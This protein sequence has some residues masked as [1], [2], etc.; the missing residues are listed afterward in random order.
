MY[1]H[2]GLHI[3]ATVGGGPPI[4]RL[5]LAQGIVHL[6]DVHIGFQVDHVGSS[7][8]V[9]LEVPQL[10]LAPRASRARDSSRAIRGYSLAVP[11]STTS[12]YYA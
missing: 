1:F 3:V 9:Q 2:A 6:H 12:T 7:Y 8:V 10:S 5:L 11:V 4:L